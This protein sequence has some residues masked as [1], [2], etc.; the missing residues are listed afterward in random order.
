MMNWQ[1]HLQA[2]TPTSSM[3]KQNVSKAKSNNNQSQTFTCDLLK[4]AVD[5]HAAFLMVAWQMDGSNPKAPQKFAVEA[6][7]RGWPS[8]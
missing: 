3:N 2:G 6:F 5:A 4:V 7:V 8:R 1:A